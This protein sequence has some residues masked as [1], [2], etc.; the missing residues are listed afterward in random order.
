MSARVGGIETATGYSGL[1]ERARLLRHIAIVTHCVPELDAVVAAWTRHWHY[2]AP[3][4][5][6]GAAPAATLT[7]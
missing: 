6:L 3:T 4:T 7:R 5:K 2:D 1:G